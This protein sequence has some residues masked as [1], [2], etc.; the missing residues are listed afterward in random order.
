MCA[1]LAVVTCECLSEEYF[2]T[3]YKHHQKSEEVHCSLFHTLSPVLSC[4]SCLFS[5]SDF[6]NAVLF[7]VFTVTVCGA[8]AGPIYKEFISPA[9]IR[10]QPTH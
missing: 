1:R 8:V 3:K 5:S 4:E 2:F 7:L 9:P 10:S 6:S